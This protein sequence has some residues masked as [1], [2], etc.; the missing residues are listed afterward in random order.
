[1]LAAVFFTERFKGQLTRP[2]LCSRGLPVALW[3]GKRFCDRT[4]KALFCR[5][6]WGRWFSL[7]TQ[8][9]E[10]L[11]RRQVGAEGLCFTIR[12]GQ[13]QLRCTS[14]TERDGDLKVVVVMICSAGYLKFQRP[15]EAPALY[16]NVF[17][18]QRNTLNFSA[19]E[20]ND[21]TDP[22]QCFHAGAPT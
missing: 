13:S 4:L 3:G 18:E 10:L 19:A 22:Q 15:T 6:W 21:Q 7:C 17:L 2:R 9:E 12:K 1:M 20:L 16:W 11:P 5:R 14:R 8:C